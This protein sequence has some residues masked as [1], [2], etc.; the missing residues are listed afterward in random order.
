MTSFSAL[1]IFGLLVESFKN[2]LAL[3]SYPKWSNTNLIIVFPGP[4]N[5][6]ISSQVVY[7]LF[8]LG[9]WEHGNSRTWNLQNV[10]VPA[11]CLQRSYI[12][13]RVNWYLHCFVRF[14]YFVV[15]KL[16]LFKCIFSNSNFWSYK[17]CTAWEFKN[18]S[19]I[20]IVCY[21]EFS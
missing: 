16:Q 11:R 21:F 5:D 20:L 1:L 19:K 14:K 7:D 17:T 13:I 10:I 3:L 6:R 18:I 12:H 15:Y 2:L 9:K 8:P 4:F